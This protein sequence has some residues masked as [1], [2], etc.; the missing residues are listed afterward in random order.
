[1]FYAA[2]ML[3]SAVKALPME[4]KDLEVSI[5]EVN[6]EVSSLEKIDEFPEVQ[7]NLVDE[8]EAEELDNTKVSEQEVSTFEDTTLTEQESENIEKEFVKE[9]E[10]DSSEKIDSE[11]ESAPYEDD[12]KSLTVDEP[13]MT[14]EEKEIVYG[15]PIDLC[16]S[17]NNPRFPLHLR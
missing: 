11:P 15:I 5:N 8:E 3:A 4:I 14:E 2:L 10:K 17:Y 12:S 16:N 1:V 7:I 9:I 13:K 6:A